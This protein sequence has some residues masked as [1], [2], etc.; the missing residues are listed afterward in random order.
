MVVIITLKWVPFLSLYKDTSLHYQRGLLNLVLFCQWRSGIVQ[1]W[2]VCNIHFKFVFKCKNHIML[3]R[4]HLTRADFELT[5][6]VVICTDW[7]GKL[8]HHFERF[9]VAILT[10]LTVTEYMLT[11]RVWRYQRRN[12]IRT[13]NT[14]AKR[15]MT[16]RT[17]LKTVVN[18]GAAEG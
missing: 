18:S 6:L 5:T 14:M 7:I 8:S 17:P 9:T 16:T 10:W 13:D 12:R 3:Y 11:R 15:K 2:I 4:V 1:N